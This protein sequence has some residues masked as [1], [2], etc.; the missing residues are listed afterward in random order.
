IA[1]AR[2]CLV[3]GESQEDGL[4]VPEVQ[5]ERRQTFGKPDERTMGSAKPSSRA[6]FSCEDV[7]RRLVYKVSK[8]RQVS[9]WLNFDERDNAINQ[10]CIGESHGSKPEKPMPKVVADDPA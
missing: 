8:Q 5:R 3:G 2:L 7:V 6:N 4:S 1:N 10:V 9:A